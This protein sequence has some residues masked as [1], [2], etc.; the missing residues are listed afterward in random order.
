MALSQPASF[1]LAGIDLQVHDEL[2]LVIEGADGAGV[3]LL[4][5]ELRPEL[6]VGALR[7]LAEAEGAAIVGDEALHRKRLVVLEVNDR[8]LQRGIAFIDNLA[9]D[10]ALRGPALFSPGICRARNA[11]SNQHQA[12]GEQGSDRAGT[13]VE[14]S[15][16]TKREAQSRDTEAETSHTCQYNGRAR[17]PRI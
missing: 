5:V 11:G 10:D 14:A 9:R 13:S 17:S 12:E 15:G 6:V 16:R 3:A 8:T 2:V 4:A 1:L 7:E